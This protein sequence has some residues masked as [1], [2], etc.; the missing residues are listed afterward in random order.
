MVAGAVHPDVEHASQQLENVP[1]HAPPPFGAR[2]FPAVLLSEHEVFPDLDVRQQVTKAG[3]PH[4]D[5]EAHF[6]TKRAQL[7]FVSAAV[8]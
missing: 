7:L 6:L 3:L 5:F 1:T 2:H 8:A 4:V